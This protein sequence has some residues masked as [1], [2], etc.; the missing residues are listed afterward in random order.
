MKIFEKVPY[1]V[2]VRVKGDEQTGY[3]VQSCISYNRFFPFMNTWRT[4]GSQGATWG[5]FIFKTL[6][7]A[8]AV[9]AKEYKGWMDFYEAR[10]WERQQTKKAMYLKSVVNFPQ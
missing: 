4:I 6:E 7:E 2:K 5:E 3:V 1:N 9:A 10:E 8:E